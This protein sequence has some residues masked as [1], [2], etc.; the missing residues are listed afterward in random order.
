MQ[1]P[2]PF[3]NLVIG[4][5]CAEIDGFQGGFCLSAELLLVIIAFPG[6]KGVVG[7]V[8]VTAA[9]AVRGLLLVWARWWRFGASDVGQSITARGC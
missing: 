7:S 9:T 6:W 2:Y 5:L 3:Y 8:V 1:L 4:P